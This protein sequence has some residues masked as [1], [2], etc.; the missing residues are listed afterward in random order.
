[1][2]ESIAENTARMKMVNH[3]NG[4]TL[5]STELHAFCFPLALAAEVELDDEGTVANS[6]STTVYHS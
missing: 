3:F 2:Q 1:M 4:A 5:E 6:D